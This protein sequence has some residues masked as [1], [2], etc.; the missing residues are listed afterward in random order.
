M[1][2]LTALAG[3]ALAVLVLCTVGCTQSSAVRTCRA[4]A[5]Q[6]ENDNASYE[7]EYDS[8]LG[9]TKVGQLTTSDLLGRD[10]ELIQCMQT[11]PHNKAQY[12]AVLYRNGFIEGE[13]VQ[14]FLM[15]SEQMHDFG[16]WEQTQQAT[17]L[18][19]Y[20]AAEKTS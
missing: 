18:A 16:I 10:Q 7:A 20:R 17:T 11:D 15:A 2:L 9:A 8:L 5:Q 3:V 12:K 1:R 14:K 4:D 6:F 13:R 19:S